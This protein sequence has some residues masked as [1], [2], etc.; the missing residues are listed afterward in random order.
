M[1]HSTERVREA[2]DPIC[3][4]PKVLIQGRPGA[5]QGETWM[6]PPEGPDDW[7]DQPV[8]NTP[9]RWLGADA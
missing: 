9:P 3:C 2:R 8:G 4:H 1:A 7:L 5:Y 6:L